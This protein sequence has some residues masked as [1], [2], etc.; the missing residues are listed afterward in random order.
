M[1]QPIM[2][3]HFRRDKQ[4]GLTVNTVNLMI[5]HKKRPFAERSRSGKLA[6]TPLS[7]RFNLKLSRFK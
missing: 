3:T 4:K 6:S 7:E 1:A 5:K 2:A